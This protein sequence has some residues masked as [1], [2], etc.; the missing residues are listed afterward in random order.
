MHKKLLDESYTVHGPNE[1]KIKY[2]IV[3]TVY[4]F[5]LDILHWI[6]IGLK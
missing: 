3:N 4:S 1:Y 2:I 6:Y 5:N